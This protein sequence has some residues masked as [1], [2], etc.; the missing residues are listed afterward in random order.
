MSRPVTVEEFLARERR[1]DVRYVFDGVRPQT[2]SEQKR[3]LT[4]KTTA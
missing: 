4:S 2:I 1:Q 3:R